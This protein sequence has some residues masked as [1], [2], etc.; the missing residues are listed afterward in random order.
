M[1]A[2]II[3]LILG[4][5]VGLPAYF[6]FSSDTSALVKKSFEVSSVERGVEVPFYYRLK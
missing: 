6:F 5:T 3:A 1:K 2:T 4:V